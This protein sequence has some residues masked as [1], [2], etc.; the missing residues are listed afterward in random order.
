VHIFREVGLDPSLIGYKRI[1]RCVARWKSL[2]TNTANVGGMGGAG[3]AG[4]VASMG[5]MVGMGGAIGA[6]SAIGTDDAA[7]GYGIG[8]APDFDDDD[9]G[10]FRPQSGPI[11]SFMPGTGMFSGTGRSGSLDMRDLLIC[12]QIRQIDDLERRLD[13]LQARLDDTGNGS[14]AGKGDDTDQEQAD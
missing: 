7:A 2:Y 8:G 1:E 13:D 14:D 4:G 10:E 6:N 3:S 11:A 9:G 12:Q 5:G